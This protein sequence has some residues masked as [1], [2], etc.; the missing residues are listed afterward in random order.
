[1]KTLH[2]SEEANDTLK[3]YVKRLNKHKKTGAKANS[4]STVEALIK[5][6]ATLIVDPFDLTVGN[7]RK[8]L[9]DIRR[10]LTSNHNYITGVVDNQY[11]KLAKILANVD[12]LREELI[13]NI[14]EAKGEYYTAEKLAGEGEIELAQEINKREQ[15]EKISLNI[16]ND[17][18]SE[19]LEKDMALRIWRVFE[20]RR[21]QTFESKKIQ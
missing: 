1:M 4:K 10:K 6:G 17:V 21:E 9:A 14:P 16:L 5:Y 3:S 11:T 7:T 19:E 13:E 18:L 2:I 12:V 8:E 15:R 20:S